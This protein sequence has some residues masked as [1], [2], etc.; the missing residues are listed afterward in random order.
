MCAIP[1]ELFT[2]IPYPVYWQRICY[3]INGQAYF[4]NAS[5][6]NIQSTSV[7]LNGAVVDYHG[8]VRA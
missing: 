5:G 6:I 7:I 8:R 2:Y 1:E 3:R 4:L